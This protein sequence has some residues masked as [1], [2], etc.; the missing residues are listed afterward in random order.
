MYFSHCQK[1]ELKHISVLLL[2]FWILNPVFF[3]LAWAHWMKN[4]HRT[5]SMDESSSSRIMHDSLDKREIKKNKNKAQ[6]IDLWY[7][8]NPTYGRS[9]SFLLLVFYFNYFVCRKTTHC[10]PQGEMSLVLEGVHLW[11]NLFYI[12][13]K[14]MSQ[15]FD[16]KSI[17]L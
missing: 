14:I 12:K 8:D 2:H 3:H 15:I 7:T 13:L 4:S 9:H 11:S 16:T 17:I 6:V 5:I 10:Q 1:I